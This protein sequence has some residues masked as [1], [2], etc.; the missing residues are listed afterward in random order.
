MIAG[1]TILQK[2]ETNCDPTSRFD[3]EMVILLL[4]DNDEVDDYDRMANDTCT[5]IEWHRS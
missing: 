1:M 4:N 2:S 3:M 5:L